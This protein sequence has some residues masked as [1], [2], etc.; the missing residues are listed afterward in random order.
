MSLETESESVT[1]PPLGIRVVCWARIVL[2]VFEVILMFWLLANF[3]ALYVAVLLV[4]IAG[5]VVIMYGLWTLQLWG[6]VL[7]LVWYSIG[8]V[9]SGVSVLSGSMGSLIGVIFSLI[10]VGLVLTNYQFFR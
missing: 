8:V 2:V 7:A 5:E 4:A 10:I 9:Q 3:E 1:R 6:W